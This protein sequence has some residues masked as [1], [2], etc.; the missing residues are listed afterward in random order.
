MGVPALLATTRD[1]FTLCMDKSFC[2]SY[3]LQ[4]RLSR[5]RWLSVDPSLCVCAN[6]VLTV[7]RAKGLTPGRT[8]GA[9]SHLLGQPARFSLL[10]PA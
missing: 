2:V 9:M 5:G 3:N 4:G 1:F 7:S 8:H 10:H 6:E